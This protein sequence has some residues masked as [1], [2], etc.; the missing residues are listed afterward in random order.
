MMEESYPTLEPRH[1]EPQPCAYIPRVRRDWTHGVRTEVRLHASRR[2][3]GVEM[4]AR[5]NP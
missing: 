2:Y 1:R 5:S 4:E 3:G